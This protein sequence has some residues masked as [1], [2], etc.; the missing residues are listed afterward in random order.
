[1]VTVR[2]SVIASPFR[3]SWT[4]HPYPVLE[5][6]ATDRKWLEEFWEHLVLR[7]RVLKPQES[8]L[9]V[10]VRGDQELLTVSVNAVP[11]AGSVSVIYWLVSGAVLLMLAIVE[12]SRWSG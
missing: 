1:M 11:M 7:I 2:G 4:Y 8:V 9:T 6:D 3:L 12:R 5:S 10:A